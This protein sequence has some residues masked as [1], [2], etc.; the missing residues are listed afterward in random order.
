M[1]SLIAPGQLRRQQTLGSSALYRVA[2][3]DEKLI[4]L[5]VVHAPGL[6]AGARVSFTR[7]AVAAM[8][9]IAQ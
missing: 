1:T 4:T 9:A 2:A 7:Q 5:T 6:T 8:T 3:V